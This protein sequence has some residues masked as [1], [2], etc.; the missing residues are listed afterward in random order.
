ME[1]V[2]QVRDLLPQI[3]G[4]VPQDSPGASPATSITK[5]KKFATTPRVNAAW[6]ELIHAALRAWS[7]RDPESLD[8]LIKS[9]ASVRP[10]VERDWSA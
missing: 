7:W 1:V 3:I 10:W 2:S 5:S 6:D 4:R 9:I 8:A